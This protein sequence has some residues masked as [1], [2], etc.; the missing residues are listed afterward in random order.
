MVVAVYGIAVYGLKL[1]VDFKGGSVMELQFGTTAPTVQQ[2]TSVVSG[3][4]KVNNVSASPVGDKGMIVRLNDID[5]Q[6]HKNIVS[7]LN[8]KF[9]PVEEL[10]FDSVGP[11]I[12][13]ELAHKSIVAIITLIIAIAIYIAIMFRALARAVSPWAMSAATMFAL[14]HDVVI[15]VGFFAFLGRYAGVEISAVFVAAVLTILGYSISDTV[16]VFDRVREN[17]IKTGFKQP[18]G[19]IVHQSIMQTLARSLN[20]SL[21]VL[22]SLS[23]IYIFGGESVKYFALALIVGIFLG[24]YSSIFVASPLLVWWRGNRIKKA[25]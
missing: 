12:G 23:A 11:T 14:F 15:T 7:T 18:F 24:A 9:P 19:H 8:T 21:T 10:R 2:I 3:F 17:V 5:E 1:G 13:N 25:V 4:P 16:I 22:L 6:T 20:S